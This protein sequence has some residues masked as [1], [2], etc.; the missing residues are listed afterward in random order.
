MLQEK[1]YEL[2][3]EIKLKEF[4]LVQ[5]RQKHELLKIEKQGEIDIRKL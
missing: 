3:R 2:D 5:D 4:Q 1:K